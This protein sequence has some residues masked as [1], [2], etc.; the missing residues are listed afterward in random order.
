MADHPDVYA[1]GITISINPAG[2]TLT[3]T[4]SVSAIP[5]VNETAGLEIA[6]RVRL[7]RPMAEALA[8]LLQQ[9]LAAKPG[10]V[11]QT[12]SH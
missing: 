11:E 12:I 8:S 7:A 3:F 4:R 6:A 1:D 2:F 9:A 5:N 10:K